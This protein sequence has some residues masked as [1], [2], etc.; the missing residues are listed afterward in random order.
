[1]KSANN[2]TDEGS[3]PS[4]DPKLQAGGASYVFMLPEQGISLRDV[5]LGFLKQA[6]LR[7]DGNRTKA[8]KLL[9]LH[10]DQVR[11]RIKKFGIEGFGPK[12]SNRKAGDQ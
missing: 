9:G 12:P 6:L 8:G 11:Y 7:A 10:R 2:W 1:M 3:A 5:E 4:E